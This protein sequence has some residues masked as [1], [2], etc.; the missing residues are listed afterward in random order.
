MTLGLDLGEPRWGPVHKSV[1]KSATCCRNA[2]T[3]DEVTKFCAP[4]VLL[5]S[6][7]SQL[8]QLWQDA[9]AADL[10]KFTDAL[11]TYSASG[12]GHWMGIWTNLNANANIFQSQSLSGWD[13]RLAF[14]RIS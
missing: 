4:S 14:T 8:W 6:L 5:P 7:N 13:C 11:R 2:R 10:G 9:T 1:P 12:L 3:C